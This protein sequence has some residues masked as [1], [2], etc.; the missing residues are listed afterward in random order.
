MTV[1]ELPS[2]APVEVLAQESRLQGQLMYYIFKKS[3]KPNRPLFRPGRYALEISI[4]P[5][6]AIPEEP[7]F[8]D[9]NVNTIESRLVEAGSSPTAGVKR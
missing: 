7:L 4:D 2:G 6:R 9:N 3:F 1:K 8:R 5:N